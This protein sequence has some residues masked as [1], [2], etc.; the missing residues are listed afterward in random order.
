M[1]ETTVSHYISGTF[2]HSFLGSLQLGKIRMGITAKKKAE[3]AKQFQVQEWNVC[4]RNALSKSCKA[5]PSA[6]KHREGMQG[7]TKRQA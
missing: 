6:A 3:D 7:K 1:Q 2:A 5:F 4:T